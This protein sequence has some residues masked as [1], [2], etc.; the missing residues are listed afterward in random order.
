ML[1]LFMYIFSNFFFIYCSSPYIYSETTCYTRPRC[2]IGRLLRFQHIEETNIFKPISPTLRHDVLH[3]VTSQTRSFLMKC[4]VLHIVLRVMICNI[5]RSDIV[6]PIY[7]TYYSYISENIGNNQLRF[8][9]PTI[10]S[11]DSLNGYSYPITH[12]RTKSP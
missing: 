4:I 10:E 2:Y 7:P 11:R 8:F 9:S 1:Q 12:E 5:D 6:I 3:T